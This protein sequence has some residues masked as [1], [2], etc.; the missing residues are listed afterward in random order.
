MNCEI[1][2]GRQRGGRSTGREQ[3]T[4]ARKE[5]E[6]GEGQEK[7]KKEMRKYIFPPAIQSDKRKNQ[8]EATKSQERE[9]ERERTSP[10]IRIHNYRHCK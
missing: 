9:R 1:R 6:S 2:L 7:K 8:L 10:V 3:E 4:T 5:N